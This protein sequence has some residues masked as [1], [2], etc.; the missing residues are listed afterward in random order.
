VLRQSDDGSLIA[1][2]NRG[3]FQL[4]P[5]KLHWEPLNVLQSNA[6][7]SEAAASATR[8]ATTDL[9]ELTASVHG[10]EL[11]P[12]QWYAA[13]SAGL[14]VSSDLGH[15][16]HS[17]TAVPG[18][19]SVGAQG[20]MVVAAS[21][22]RVVISADKGESWFVL[23]SP[24]SAGAI[25]SIV[26]DRRGAIWLAAGEGA[27]RSQDAGDSWQRMDDLPLANVTSI[28]FDYENHRIL[29]VGADSKSI[30]ESLNNGRTWTSIESGWLVHELQIAHGNLVAATAFDGVVVHPSLAERAAE[31]SRPGNQ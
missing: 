30:F 18:L 17:A 1:G 11:G 24:Q 5:P 20:R 6:L 14:L 22:Q 9:N 7:P 4:Q 3:I 2:T 31:N 15:S 19:L 12:S 10:L 25:N 16:W 29:A 26:V 21:H 8:A 28:H 27:F 13:T 23:G